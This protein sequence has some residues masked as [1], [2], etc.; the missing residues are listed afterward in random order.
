LLSIP[1]PHFQLGPLFRP[2]EAGIDSPDLS[3]RSSSAPR[4]APTR[5]GICRAKA[6]RYKCFRARARSTAPLTPCGAWETTFC[7]ERWGLNQVGG[8]TVAAVCHRR[9]GPTCSNPLS[10]NL[11]RIY[12]L[13]FTAGTMRKLPC[14]PA[15]VLA[16]RNSTRIQFRMQEKY[17]ACEADRVRDKSGQT[18]AMVRPGKLARYKRSSRVRRWHRLSARRANAVRQPAVTK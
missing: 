3:G 14:A 10:E 6:R 1:R 5:R 2:R 17:L 12:L 18:L 8:L 15:F 4:S 13:G 16:I 11:S 9:K 7:F